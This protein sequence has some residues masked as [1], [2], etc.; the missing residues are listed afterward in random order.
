MGEG[1]GG[2]GR[3]EKG[4]VIKRVHPGRIGGVNNKGGRQERH[5]TRYLNLQGCYK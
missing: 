2:R 1:G 4:G 3:T 5:G